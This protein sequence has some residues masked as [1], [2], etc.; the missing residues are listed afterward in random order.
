MSITREIDEK[1]NIVDLV[2]RYIAIKKA[3]VNYKA[4][5]PFHNEKTASFVI[6]PVKNIAYCFSCHN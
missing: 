2:S 5:C 4:L 3:G 1:I 6:S